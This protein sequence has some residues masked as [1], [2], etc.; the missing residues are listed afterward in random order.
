MKSFTEYYLQQIGGKSI[1]KSKKWKKFMVDTYRKNKIKNSRF[2][3]NQA[4]NKTEKKF[5]S[6]KRYKK[7]L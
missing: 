3:L 5:F 6:K 1:K 4:I 7:N 2:T